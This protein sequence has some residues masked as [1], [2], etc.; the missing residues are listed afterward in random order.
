[1]NRVPV[2][3]RGDADGV[4]V[5]AIDDLAE[6]D[7]RVALAGAAGPVGVVLLDP[8]LRVLAAGLVDIADGQHL[9]LLAEEPA[10]QSPPLGAHADEGHGQPGVGLGLGRPE[11]RGQD[12]RYSDRCG[13]T[14]EKRASCGL[15]DLLLR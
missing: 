14:L 11:V 4:D 12:K 13:E 1:M 5:L 7:V 10:Q 3:R 6:V 9:R 8:L 15:H 2:I